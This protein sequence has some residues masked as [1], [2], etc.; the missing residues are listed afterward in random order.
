MLERLDAVLRTINRIVLQ[1]IVLIGCCMLII[2]WA[3]IFFRYVLNNSLSWSEELLKILLV[4]FCMLSTSIIAIR[5][6][7]V[8]IVI[9]KQQFPKRVENMFDLVMQ[10]I[11]FAVSVVVCVI[12]V[13]MIIAAGARRT[14]ALR[15]PY[16]AM[17][18]SVC[19]SF[20]VL[21]IYELRN[22]IVKLI[23]PQRPAADAE[24]LSDF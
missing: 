13:R 3:H 2:A 19:V 6:E 8:S 18:A 15:L 7:H 16:A 20:A 23:D 24:K 17:Y 10:F 22:F 11:T 12:G 21:S 1:I 4:W 9:F 14:P 5:R